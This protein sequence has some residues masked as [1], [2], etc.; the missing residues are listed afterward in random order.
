MK[1]IKTYLLI[2]A[3]L[4]SLSLSGQEVDLKSFDY[5]KAD[6]IALNLKRNSRSSEKL[7]IALT[8]GLRSEHEKF[9][10]IFRWVTDNISYG[11]DNERI[12]SKYVL[13]KK[14]SVCSGYSTLL[15]ELCDHVNV[16]CEIVNGYAKSFPEH[17]GKFRTTNHAWNAVELNGKW[18]LVDAT[19]AAGFVNRKQFSKRFNEFYFLTNP[20]EFLFTHLPSN[21]K[22]TLTEKAFSKE[23][24]EMMPI[25]HQSYFELGIEEADKIKGESGRRFVYHFKSKTP[26]VFSS[27]KFENKKEFT[28]FEM[29]ENDGVY[30]MEIN[31][32]EGEHGTCYIF[33][34]HQRVLTLI[35]NQE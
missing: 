31:F 21:P 28:S 10:A 25:Y 29:Q 35:V 5:S 16:N 2:H 12:D 18:Y 13:R 30:Q 3:I 20:D 11:F 23:E 27:Y 7:A 26:I 17:I 15:K 6:K 34:N 14:S 24:F 32:E 4:V 9:R 8:K 1:L 22:W 33:L 19:W